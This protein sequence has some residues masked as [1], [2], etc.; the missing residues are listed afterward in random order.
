M[1]INK[2]IYHHG[3]KGQKW[4]VRRTK[5]QLIHDP[6]SIAAKV[7]NRK[8]EVDTLSGKVTA[9]LTNHAIEQLSR[10]ERLL[11]AKEILDAMEHPLDKANTLRVDP[12]TKL[13]S[14][15]F[16]GQYATVNINDLTGDIS[17]LWKTSSKIVKKY[18][19]NIVK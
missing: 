13:T 19:N 4:G 3:I 17:T 10:P 16:I 8:L 14:Q 5:E 11:T 12:I 6:Y 1:Q 15:R 9:K 2:E 7:N 18:A